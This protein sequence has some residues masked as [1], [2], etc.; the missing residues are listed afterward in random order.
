MTIEIRDDDE[1]TVV[2]FR[3]YAD[4]E[5]IALFPED[6]DAS[7]RCGAYLSDEFYTGMIYQD[8]IEMTEP[9]TPRQYRPMR[10]QLEGAWGYRLDVRERYERE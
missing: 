5:I 3:R 8:V 1:P 2:V 4:G 7:G 9:A 10:A 6:E